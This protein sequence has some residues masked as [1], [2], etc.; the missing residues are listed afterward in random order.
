MS[1]LDLTL[2]PEPVGIRR[3]EVITGV[4]GRRL[5]SSE[6]KARIVAETLAPEAKVSAV[7]RRF[8]LRPQQIFTWRREARRRARQST[9]PEAMAF[10]PVIVD[11]PIATQSS[12][13]H[14]EPRSAVP[15]VDVAPIEV[16]IGGAIVRLRRNVDMRTLAA[17]IG[18]LKSVR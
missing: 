1:K 16:E 18:V 10:T 7:A 9:T 12:A 2:E 8:G 17:V 13:P 3:L 6:M 4:G 15:P 11:P 14:K 5:W